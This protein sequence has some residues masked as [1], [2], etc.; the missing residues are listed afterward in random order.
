MHLKKL[1]K[2]QGLELVESFKNSG[3]KASIYCEQ[4]NVNLCVLQY[5]RSKARRLFVKN[6]KG[7]LIPIKVISPQLPR[8]TLKIT[9][10]GLMTVDVPIET[11]MLAFRKILETCKDV[12]NR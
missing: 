8:N 7:D 2:E 12:A 10:Q 6:E 9:I 1:T 11:G 5:W 3:L 4:Q